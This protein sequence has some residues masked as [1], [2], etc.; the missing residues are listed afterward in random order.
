MRY[1]PAI[2]LFGCASAVVG[3]AGY[4]TVAECQ[5][6]EVPLV[7]RPWPRAYDR[8]ELRAR[9]ARG[10]VA[11]VREPAEAARAAVELMDRRHRVP[12]FVNGAVEAVARIRAIFSSRFIMKFL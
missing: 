3:G 11:V 4:N 8:Q 2:D 7:A 9:N 10:R 6:W 1:W 5:A 12:R